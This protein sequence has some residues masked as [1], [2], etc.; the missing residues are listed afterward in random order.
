[1]LRR[2]WRIVAALTIMSLFVPVTAEAAFI[3]GGMRAVAV[4]NATPPSNG[5]SLNM[6]IPCMVHQDPEAVG[7]ISGAFWVFPQRTSVTNSHFI[8]TGIT[9]GDPS[10]VNPFNGVAWRYVVY[11][12][13]TT[14]Y[15]EYWNTNISNPAASAGTGFYRNPS[16]R[17]TLDVNGS[18]TWTYPAVFQGTAQAA[19]TG[20]E[21]YNDNNIMTG[22]SEN[23]AYY[24]S[25]GAFAGWSVPTSNSYISVSHSLVNASW[26]SVHNS[27]VY[28]ENN[29]AC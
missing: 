12:S 20:L 29:V 13:S 16:N 6:R 19:Q 9:R 8:E 18:L 21:S 26:T 2:I 10:M 22:Y 11:N 25:S 1:M 27:L 14:G 15:H 24:T 5:Y 28:V 17:W 4:W 7:F 3:P 23:L